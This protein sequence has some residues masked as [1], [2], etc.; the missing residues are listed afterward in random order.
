MATAVLPLPRAAENW[1]KGDVGSA[2][3]QRTSRVR[4]L[5]TAWPRLKIDEATVPCVS[6]V[7]SV[8]VCAPD[9]SARWVGSGFR[10]TLYSGSSVCSSFSRDMI[11]VRGALVFGSNRMMLWR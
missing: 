9:T 3:T 2:D 6:I 1:L 5:M 4:V 10:K 8:D 11:A 7:V